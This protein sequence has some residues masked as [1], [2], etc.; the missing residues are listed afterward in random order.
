MKRQERELRLLL[1]KIKI[2]LKAELC[3]LIGLL[4]YYD[5]YGMNHHSLKNLFFDKGGHSIFSATMFLECR[6]LF[7]S[8]ST[9]HDPEECKEKLPYDRS[10]AAH[11]LFKMFSSNT[12]KYLLPFLY[13]STVKIIH[14]MKH[15]IAFWH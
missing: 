5:L 2:C 1:R 7:L 9:F 14:P 15:Q 13:L 11:P 12:S 3:S 8:T 10:A 4:C 6:K